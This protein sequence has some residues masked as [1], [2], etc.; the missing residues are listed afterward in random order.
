METQLITTRDGETVDLAELRKR[1]EAMGKSQSGSDMYSEVDRHVALYVEGFKQGRF[2]TIS[3]DEARVFTPYLDR[4]Y[5]SDI[6]NLLLAANPLVRRISRD[7]LTRL[8]NEQPRT[9]LVCIY[10]PSGV[11]KSTLTGHH[12]LSE[13]PLRF[14]GGTACSPRE[15]SELITSARQD[16]PSRKIMFLGLIA[17]PEVAAERVVYRMLNAEK[18]IDH[19]FFPRYMLGGYEQARRSYVALANEAHCDDGVSI[20][21]FD[22]TKEPVSIDPRHLHTIDND[23]ELAY[24]TAIKTL[25]TS[26][27]P[28]ATPYKG[29]SL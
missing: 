15:Y 5:E 13:K 26:S 6:S 14:E 21:F 12:I 4:V 18:P 19:R 16:N 17:C 1:C 28:R 8:L 25:N 23:K 2:S 27:S 29:L 20:S 22:T 7:A 3:T 9:P 11:G 10:G 24:D